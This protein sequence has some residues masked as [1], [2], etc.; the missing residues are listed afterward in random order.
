MRASCKGSKGNPQKESFKHTGS[1]GLDRGMA[2]PLEMAT[3][4]LLE[5]LILRGVGDNDKCGKNSWGKG[6]AAG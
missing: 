2:V 3:G 1:L 4:K 6:K 5:V